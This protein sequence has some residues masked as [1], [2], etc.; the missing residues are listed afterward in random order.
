MDLYTAL[1]WFE[2]ETDE[3][4]DLEVCTDAGAGY[5]IGYATAGEWLEYSVDV[6]KYG[7]Y[8]VSFRVAA[9]GD[10]RT[11]SLSMEGK[12]IATNVAIPNTAGWQ[13]GRRG[14]ARSAALPPPGRASAGCCARVRCARAASGR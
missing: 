5:N 7:L 13:A 14:P 10:A 11:I 12:D 1:K 3:D 8:D 6:Q 2:L 9:S 4:V